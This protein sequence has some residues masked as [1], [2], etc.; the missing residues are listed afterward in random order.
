MSEITRK[1]AIIIDDDPDIVT[2][3]AE[4]LDMHDI[5]AIGK[6]YDGKDAVE[7]YEKLIPDV[8]FLDL[9]MPRYDGFYGLEKIKQISPSAIVIMI[10]ADIRPSSISKLQRLGADM[11][12]CKPFEIDSILAAINRLAQYEVIKNG[13]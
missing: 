13:A 1:T 6:G 8:V 11:I 9:M 4:Y 2:T 12:I 7:L 3:L 10:T 5:H